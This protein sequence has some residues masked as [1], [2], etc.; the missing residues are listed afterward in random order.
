MLNSLPNPNQQTQQFKTTLNKLPD[1]LKTQ[2]L[3]AIE[4]VGLSCVPRGDGLYTSKSFISLKPGAADKTLWRSIIG[5]TPHRLAA[6][7]YLPPDTVM[8]E[9]GTGDLKQSWKLINTTINTLGSQ[10]T[11]KSF[12][13]NI[14]QTSNML[15]IDI[16]K[17]IATA[18]SETFLALTLGKESSIDI[19]YA[20]GQKLTIP[21][22]AILI[23]LAVT[24]KTLESTLDKL[25][26]SA[27]LPIQKS[28]ISGT[29]IKTINLPIPSPVP[30]AVSFATHKNMFLLGSTPKSVSDAI[31][32][33]E[34][35]NGLATSPE[36]KKAFTSLPMENNELSYVSQRMIDTIADIQTKL[37]NSS[38]IKN[39]PENAMIIKRMMKMQGMAPSATVLVSTKTGILSH[40]VS[41]FN[42]RQ[43]IAGSTVAPMGLMA[44]IAIPSF[45]KARNTSQKNACINNLRMIDSAKEQAALEYS[46]KNGHPIEPGSPDEAK[47]ME[48]LKNR[49]IPRCPCGGIYTIG[50]IG[51][52]P[53]CSNAE[54]TLQAY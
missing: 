15:G 35:K 4:G 27:Q 33:C 31:T 11:I 19:P 2:G 37:I 30:V 23:G 47:V 18:G 20:P 39:S 41:S 32:A 44:A 42:G 25:L 12:N 9:I 1:F 29:D 54:H 22:P 36:F 51:T 48:Y 50:P 43:L 10:K 5:T 45:V 53:T 8:A 14:A 13:E 46:W 34:N 16:D 24:D 3:Y 28:T 52:L 17:L 21:P 40:S 49:T 38:L 7:D 6:L 26:E